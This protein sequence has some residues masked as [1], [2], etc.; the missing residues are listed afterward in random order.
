MILLLPLVWLL[1]FFF[2]RLICL[3]RSLQISLELSILLASLIWGG[4]LVLMTEILGMIRMLSP[5]PVT[6]AWGLTAFLLAVF[7]L[8]EMVRLKRVP[9]VKEWFSQSEGI[10]EWGVLHYLVVGI[11][12]IQMLVLGLIAYRYAPSTWDSMT[13][14]LPRVMQWRQNESMQHFATANQRQIQMP[15]FSEMIFLHTWLLSGSDRWVNFIQYFS[16]IIS[17]FAVSEITNHLTRNSLARWRAVLFA[18]AIPMGV[19]QA[20]STQNDYVTAMWVLIFYTLGILAI[21]NDFHPGVI[22]LASLSAGLGVLTKGTAAVFMAPLGMI[23]A[24][25]VVSIHRRRAVLTGLLSCALILLINSGYFS[26][27]FRTYGSILGPTS[28]Y[29]NESISIKVVGS[30]LL[31]NTALHV[32]VGKSIAPLSAVG[33][34]TLELLEMIHTLLGVDPLDP[35]ITLSSHNAF[36]NS[37]GTTVNEDFS[38]N[39]LHLLLIF[40]FIVLAIFSWNR[41][42][43]LRRTYFVLVLLV[44]ILFIIIFKWQVWGSRLQLPIFLLWSPLLAIMPYLAN[45]KV[46]L[47][48]PLGLVIFS[49]RWIVKN[50]TRPLDPAV[51]STP[52]S[53]NEEYFYTN[54]IMYIPYDVATSMIVESGCHQVGLKIGGNA[55]EYQLWLFLEQKGFDGTIAHIDVRNPS[56]P[57][58]PPDY[59]P[60][61]IISDTRLQE[62]EDY[63][64]IQFESKGIYLYQEQ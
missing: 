30:N 12:V 18:A 23:L 6:S 44:S 9:S 19:L 4:L 57:Y 26:R 29:L 20:T 33:D 3:R 39:A 25:G 58:F 52:K 61:A 47:I 54:K 15:P 24:I 2:V 27:N 60:C 49:F 16:F 42:S 50:P 56:K 55:H 41:F 22:S 7:V 32:P 53:R 51:F 28:R 36:E 31:R 35:R 8:L 14:H 38:G 62:R 45:R 43:K 46:W 11:F 48:V 59:V 17:M 21:K 64:N 63:M 40:I 13:Y 37:F 34:A 1:L 5:V 10:R